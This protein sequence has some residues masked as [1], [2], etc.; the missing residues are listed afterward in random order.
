MAR[1]TE[2]H[3]HQ[4]V[5]PIDKETGGRWCNFDSGDPGPG[6]GN[7]ELSQLGEGH[8][9]HVLLL[10]RCLDRFDDI[11]GLQH[12]HV[13]GSLGRRQGK[14]NSTPTREQRSSLH[15]TPRSQLANPRSG[16]GYD[17]LE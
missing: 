4:S 7:L 17:W 15:T 10:H 9:L 1:H 6:T 8:A 5:L 12:A 11:L 13:P 14:A 16:Q 2:D 3:L